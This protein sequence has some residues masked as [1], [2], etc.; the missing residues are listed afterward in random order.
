MV[1]LAA[2]FK[3]IIGKLNI[4]WRK[5]TIGG[6]IKSAVRSLNGHFVVGFLLSR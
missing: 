1:K 3:I 5:Y 6:A 4:G 2:V